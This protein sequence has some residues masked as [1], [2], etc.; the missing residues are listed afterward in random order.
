M[1]FFFLFIFAITYNSFSQKRPLSHSD[2]DGWTSISETKI[3][4]NGYW[5]A[6]S[7]LPQDGD[8]KMVF[9]P[10]M[11]KSIDTVSRAFDLKLSQDSE[12][13]VFKISPTKS[14]LKKANL[15]KKK[16]EDLPKDS[17]G[18]YQINKQELE[19]IPNIKS[20]VFP[21][22]TNAYLS[23]LLNP[24]K[25]LKKDTS[26]TTKKKKRKIESEE[27]GSKLLLVNYLTKEQKTFPFVSQ[28]QMDKTGKQLVFSTTGNDSTY[29]NGIYTFDP[30]SGN[31]KNILRLKGN[32]K[33]ITS[34][35]DGTQ[36]AFVVDPD[37]T[38]K[39]LKKNHQLWYWKTD[40]ASAELAAD[41]TKMPNLYNWKVSGDY[42]PKFS[43]DGSKL[44][45]GTYPQ[46][47]LKDTT[48]LE[49]EIVS[50]DVWNWQDKKLMP[51]QL[52]NLKNDLKKSFLTVFSTSNKRIVQLASPEIPQ[53]VQSKDANEEVVLAVS[54]EKYSS[55]H[56]FFNSPS[57]IYTIST[58]DGQATRIFENARISNLSISPEGKYIVWYAIQDTAWYC[59]QIRNNKILKLTNANSFSNFADNDVPDYPQ[60]Y[61]M[62]G[63]TKDDDKILLYDKFDIWKF[64]P[65]KIADFKKLTNGSENKKTYRYI[66]TE[67]KETA[68]DIRKALLL[69]VFDETTKASGYAT[70]TDFFENKISPLILDNFKFSTKVWKAKDASEL[71]FTKENFETFPDLQTTS[72]FDF[73]EIRKISNSNPQQKNRMWGKAEL[74]K[75][76]NLEGIELEGILYKPENFDSTKKYPMI[77]YFYEKMSD[78]LNNYIVP[79]PERASI[80]FSYY[81][82]NGY[83]VFVPNIIY[84]K[85]Y[86]G[87][88]AYDC[89][90]SGIVKVLESNFIDKAKLGIQGH[91][92]GGYQTAYLITKTDIFAA[93][94]AGAPVANM[95]SAYGGIRWDTGHSRQ[96][97]YEL[98]QSRIGATLWEKP[99]MYIENSPL[100]YL[101]NIKTPLLMMHNDGDGAVPWY[102]G[103]ELFMGLKRLN[104]PVWMINYNGEKHG[105]IQRKNRVDW[106]NRMSQYFDH[107]LKNEPAP[108]WLKKGIPATQKTLNYGFKLNE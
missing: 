78:E 44:F 21:E 39:A 85:G 90:M 52:A 49:D 35:D 95:T 16:K 27:N 7:L 67:E 10:L 3:S 11:G 40:M 20:F 22:N 70:Y 69:H 93:A 103:V 94:E 33:S 28:Y 79:Q 86:P 64:D 101:P 56:W 58:K 62:A 43:K 34:S 83:V 106:T 48:R 50:V 87:Q 76:R 57:D 13:A 47:L 60:S 14:Q 97:N 91:S 2:Y 89:I 26:I 4:N 55:Q 65:N 102:Q 105:L 74:I 99:M 68:I 6:Y 63:W 19:K 96:A 108:E 5:V 84:K 24:E 42:E 51:Q 53:I 12:W 25:E 46:P 72:G 92:W 23:I 104:K 107:Y 77:T 9:Y 32:F 73:K 80:N 41:S 75:W 31:L 88:S 18:I 29:L 82:S 100:F 1:K 61:G 71:V 98:T 59:Y 38:K 36:W 81:T 54:D 17:L 30:N 8:S 66:K 37:T 45:F 15:A